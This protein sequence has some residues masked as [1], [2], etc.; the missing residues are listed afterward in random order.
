MAAGR[1]SI[2]Y[3]MVLLIAALAVI[4]APALGQNTD[5]NSVAPGKEV[6]CTRPTHLVAMSPSLNTALHEIEKKLEIGGYDD[7]ILALSELGKGDLLS[8][9]RAMLSYYRGHVRARIDEL[10]VAAAEY[11]LA[12]K[13]EASS[14]DHFIADVDDALT[15]LGVEPTL[16]QG[17]PA[18]VRKAALYLPIN[19]IAPIY[20]HRAFT[21]GIEGSATL[22]F[23]ISEKGEVQDVRVIK[24]DPRGYF[25]RSAISAVKRRKYEPVLACG[26]PIKVLGLT[27]T[28]DYKLAD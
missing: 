25:E 26:R 16:V 13:E 2:Y 7:A 24:S 20:P 1:N 3:G 5:T 22:T 19:R 15:V 10:L 6:A 23:S 28:I 14:P 11:R 4:R 18:I 9:D 27:N 12:L 17:H 8:F 21:R